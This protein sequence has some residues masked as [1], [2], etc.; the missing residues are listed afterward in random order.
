ME[1]F[2]IKGLPVSGLGVVT[3]AMLETGVWGG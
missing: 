1:L 2:K 3:G